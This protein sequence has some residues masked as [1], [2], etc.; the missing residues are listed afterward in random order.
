MKKSYIDEVI[1]KLTSKEVTDVLST[2]DVESIISLMYNENVEVNID[3]LVYIK[4]TYKVLSELEFNTLIP[5]YGKY[6]NMP[7]DFFHKIDHGKYSKYEYEFLLKSYLFL[8]VFQKDD[9]YK[10]DKENVFNDLVKSLNNSRPDNCFTGLELIRFMVR[11]P[12]NTIKTLPMIEII[13]NLGVDDSRLKIIL[14]LIDK[15]C[16]Y[17][18]D[19][20]VVTKIANPKFTHETM[21]NLY[22]LYNKAYDDDHDDD[23]L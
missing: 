3:K 18:V 19:P 17:D 4:K 14:R 23:L 13:S 16:G 10:K 11:N 15:D 6:W 22:N 9:V 2:K 20:D 8:F 7:L 5:V 21:E 1:N 12:F